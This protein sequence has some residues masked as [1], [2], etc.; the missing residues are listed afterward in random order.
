MGNTRLFLAAFIVAT[1]AEFAES[2]SRVPS[3]S[4]PYPFGVPTAPSRPAAAPQPSSAV[5]APASQN[6]PAAPAQQIIPYFPVY[7]F[8][9]I[10]GTYGYGYLYPYGWPY[11]YAYPPIYLPPGTLY[12]SQV[13]SPAVSVNRPAPR[14]PRDQRQAVPEPPEPNPA[15]QRATNAQATALGQKYIGYGDAWFAKGKYFDAN[16]R[17]RDAARSAPQLAD[18]Y[19]RQGFALAA[20]GNYD[21]AVKVMRRGLAIDP[22]WPDSPFRLDDLYGPN[23][24]AK[25]T[26]F[27]ALPRA[28]KEKPRDADAAFLLGVYYHFNGQ[29]DLAAES[30]NRAARLLG[31]HSQF[32]EGFLSKEN[33]PPRGDRTGE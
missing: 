21:A 2:Q 30:F 7:G 25:N 22:R 9:P 11:G 10:W 29:P 6:T 4:N 19:F 26:Q 23:A 31:G 27:S 28:A 32:I 33:G 3:G 5:R 16:A 12:G 8:D 13:S 20:L 24:A 14:P 17:Y 15:D 18:A 1:A